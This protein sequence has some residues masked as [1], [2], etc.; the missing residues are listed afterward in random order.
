MIR[1][2][3]KEFPVAV[4]YQNI[5]EKLRTGDVAI[6]GGQYRI[7]RLIRLFTRFPA[8]HMALI[9]KK[10][11]RIDFVE[12]SEGDMYP[13]R[14]GVIINNFSNSM[15]FYKGDIWIARLSDEVRSK[16]D[17]Q[18]MYDFILEQVGKGYD[19]KNMKKAGFDLLDSFSSITRNKEDASEL[20]CS[21]LVALTF[22]N[23]G[24][25]PE[26]ENISELTP[27]DLIKLSLYNPLYYQIKSYNYKAVKLP[28]FNSIPTG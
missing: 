6:F 28:G 25:L 8:S 27:A 23:A 13:E 19:Y 2:E 9:I 18:E 4:N 5:R 17:E 15:P 20:F 12:A 26:N 24:I 11:D 16:I 10:N 22:K 3:K 21:E 1:D 7:S 14:E